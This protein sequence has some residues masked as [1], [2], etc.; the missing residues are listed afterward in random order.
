M[1]IG[2]IIVN[3]DAV[4][5][6]K[7]YRFYHKIQRLYLVSS[8]NKII[9]NHFYCL[10][11][12]ELLNIDT[13]KCNNNLKRHY[14][15]CFGDVTDTDSDEG[16][17]SILLKTSSY[18]QQNNFFCIE[19][20]VIKTTSKD[21]HKLIRFAIKNGQKGIKLSV[22]SLKFPTNFSGSTV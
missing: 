3:K 17:S 2:K 9:Q 21:L 8:E 20:V 10:K 11:C 15:K 14:Q 4:K 6:S 1:F 22:D 7:N 18:P 16:R 5:G 13:G 12:E 19:N